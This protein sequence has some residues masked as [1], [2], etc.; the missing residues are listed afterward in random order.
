MQ[1]LNN[2]K[3]FTLVE[4]VI[5]IAVIAILAAVLIPVFSNMIGKAQDSAALQAAR[6]TLTEYMLNNATSDPEPDLVIEGG[7][8]RY[9]AIVSGEFTVDADG[10]P[11]QYD[12][13]TAAKAAVKAELGT[14]ESW[15]SDSATYKYT[16][17]FIATE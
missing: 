4:L 1:K 14:G 9:Y 10:N 11:V 13:D 16:I 5:V 8:G 15:Q 12:T 17:Y 6:N 7:E 3:G 2:K